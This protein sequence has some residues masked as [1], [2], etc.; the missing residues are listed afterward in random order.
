[1]DDNDNDD[2]NDND[3]DTLNFLSRKKE[4]VDGNMEPGFLQCWTC[5]L[6]KLENLFFNRRYSLLIGDDVK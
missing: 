1:M 5:A 2:Y 3:V 6:T 4:T